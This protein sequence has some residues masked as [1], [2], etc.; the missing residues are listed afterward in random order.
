VEE[1]LWLIGMMG[2]GKT[3][4]ARALGRRWGVPAIDTDAEVM[5]RTGCSI[6][7]L[8]GERGE[9]AF[10]T[11]ESAA[12]LRVAAA[13]P[14]VVSTGGGVVLDPSNTE[15][16][17]RSGRIVWLSVSP[18]VLSLRVGDG[19]GR[20]LL[21]L[22]ASE[23]ALRDILDERSAVYSAAADLTIDATELT[24]DETADRIEAWWNPS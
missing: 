8:W 15:A 19:S 20:P 24:V 1:H 4:T 14:A 12:L 2:S 13:D 6:A 21:D 11:M 9:S 7:R 3:A 22:D 17:H 23:A 5:E 16:M 10:R 18:S